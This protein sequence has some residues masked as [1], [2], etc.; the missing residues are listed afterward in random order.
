MTY[1]PQFSSPVVPDT[2]SARADPHAEDGDLP[3]VPLT[4]LTGELAARAWLREFTPVLEA[5]QAPP[6]EVIGVENTFYGHTVTVAG[7]LSGADLRR[8]LLAIPAEPTRTVVLSPRVFNAEDLTLDGMTLQD[9]ARGQPHT[10][11]VGQEDG[12]VAF[13][14]ALG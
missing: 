7:L 4:V 10:L 3:T 5:A 6:V 14:S 2:L 11:L 9:I 13:W 12:F 8:A 1:I